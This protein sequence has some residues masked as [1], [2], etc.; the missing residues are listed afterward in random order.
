MKK[1]VNITL[2]IALT[3]CGF[4]QGADCKYTDH[5]PVYSISS[6]L[7]GITV[8]GEYSIW[9]KCLPNLDPNSDKYILDN[10]ITK[11]FLICEGFDFTN[12]NDI[13]SAYRH[14]DG[15]FF[16]KEDG[17]SDIPLNEN[18]LTELRKRGYDIIC[19]NLLDNISLIQ[20]NAALYQA[21]IVEIQN[22]LTASGSKHQITA[23]GWSMG[24]LITRY[25]LTK[26]EYEGINH[27]V[28]KFITFDSPHRGANVPLGYSSFA[29]FA[30]DNA[31]G[32]GGPALNALNLLGINPVKFIGEHLN[33]K[34]GFAKKHLAAL[35]MGTMVPFD[36][37]LRYDFQQDLLQMGNYP[38]KCRKIALSS[39]ASGTSSGHPKGGILMEWKPGI[40]LIDRSIEMPFDLG[41]FQL[42]YCPIALEW[43]ANAME[44][45]YLGRVFQ[46]DIGVQLEIDFNN[47][48]RSNHSDYY[49]QH[50]RL[51]SPANTS[52]ALDHVPG[53]YF[54][55][56][57][58]LADK[59]NNSETTIPLKWE[60]EICIRIPI[61]DVLGQDIEKCGTIGIDESITLPWY[62]IIGRLKSDYDFQFTFT[63]TLSGLDI[64]S[65]DWFMDVKQIPLYPYPRDRNVTPFDVIFPSSSNVRHVDFSQDV[66]TFLVEELAPITLYIQNR[67]FPSGYVNH[68][69]AHDIFIDNNSDPIANRSLTG[70]VF[71][72][73]GSDVSFSVPT[74]GEIYIGNGVWN[75][76]SNAH[77][78]Y[79]CPLPFNTP[80]V[81]PTSP[82]LRSSG[83]SEPVALNSNTQET[84]MPEITVKSHSSIKGMGKNASFINSLDAI[85]NLSVVAYPNP[86]KLNWNVSV[87]V[88]QSDN[89]TIAV[90]NMNGIIVYEQKGINITEA[91]VYKCLIDTD[92]LTRGIYVLKV[93]GNYQT[94]NTKLEL[95]Y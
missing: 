87:N 8:N 11:A 28:D 56:G 94:I 75:Y 65:S 49:F 93:S 41:S 42:T 43:Q 10:K 73:N 46:S 44:G 57:K 91:G 48:D 92:N 45:D 47:I 35:Q 6:T 77:F 33:D 5:S 74:D 19:L 9:Y 53:G 38:Q 95:V 72:E 82:Y 90:Y 86:T 18:M 21:L 39:G 1:I 67:T 68:Y 31:L 32:L 81:S 22:Q 7:D 63:P 78:F 58:N 79:D 70:D 51:S 25:A 71:F 50:D 27:K 85:Y 37:Q 61:P 69:E 16:R 3:H 62:K 84:G 15:D 55:V 12:E 30:L 13:E 52:P 23:S 2:L 17:K 40:C 29:I 20:Y 76:G 88:P 34:T 14:V 80:Q 64:N 24:G 4:S 36:N 60:R 26:M 66:R 59:L 83:G 54:E 89:L